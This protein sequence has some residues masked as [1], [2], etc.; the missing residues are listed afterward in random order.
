MDPYTST[1]QSHPLAHSD[2][3]K[4]RVLV[5][6]SGVETRAVIRDVEQNLILRATQLNR[7]LRRVPVSAGVLQAFLN[8]SIKTERS[9]SMQVWRNAVVGKI[10]MHLPQSSLVVAKGACRERES[11]LLELCRMQLIREFVNVR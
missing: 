9:H 1:R 4:P 6:S 11:E 5:H 8:D 3:S 7:G 10:H 2:Q